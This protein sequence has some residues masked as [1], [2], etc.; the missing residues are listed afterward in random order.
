MQAVILSIGDE[1]V[2]GQT[3]DTNSAFLAQQLTSLGFSVLYHQT[4][5]DDQSAIAAAFVQA[6]RA[7]PLVIA[8]GGLG[9]TEDDLT[10]QGLADA[11]GVS[12][13]LD[14]ASLSEIE[15]FFTRRGR[16]MV[17]GNR[18]Q[19]MHPVGS[20]M[21][22]NHTGTAPGIR[23]ALHGTTIFVVPGVPREMIALW[24]RHIRPELAQNPGA[25]NVILTA[26]IN[27]FGLGESDL[28]AR[29]GDL[30]DRAR[31]P[32]VGTTVSAGVVSARVRSEF[33]TAA[34]AHAHMDQTLHAIAQI[35]GPFVYSRDDVTLQEELLKLLRQTGQK[36]ATA[37][38]CTG[39]LL[40]AM[41]TDVPG[42]SDCFLGGWVTY[43]N[44]LKQSQLDIPP[45][46]LDRHGAVS[47]QTAH[48]MAHAALV[49]S[50]ADAALSITGIA[51]PDGGTDEKPVG[52]VWVGLAVKN[53]G[54]VNVHT[55]RLALTGDR[56]II[57][58]R[59]AK[60]ALQILRFHLLGAPI[61]QI[62][63]LK[64]K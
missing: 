13:V 23:A 50:D 20:Q 57:R 58:D 54:A 45:D 25:R 16:A 6:C 11:L 12:L 56:P 38:S 15:S 48:A 53:S 21:L 4:V 44:Q 8:T 30:M 1:L 51:G 59:A 31:N 63:W 17:A 18:I 64:L 52:T 35:L 49:K 5:A 40:S 14:E 39:G 10:R 19:A 62:T 3:I 32:K 37:E 29:L 34:E 7:A 41:L 24:E 61:E 42:A 22:A 43:A 33:P 55:Y 27:T 26:K 28:A 36:I 47:S 60:T 46:I 9:P 2:L